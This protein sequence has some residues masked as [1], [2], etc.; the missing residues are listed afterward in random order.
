MLQSNLS[1]LSHYELRFKNLFVPSKQKQVQNQYRKHW[2]DTL[3]LFKAK[4]K[5]MYVIIYVMYSFL[6]RVL[7][8][9][10]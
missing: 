2:K 4:T 7:C 3:N 1:V 5:T 6:P 9:V 10:K 8:P